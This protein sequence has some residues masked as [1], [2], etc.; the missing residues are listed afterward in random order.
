MRTP[1]VEIEQ[2]RSAVHWPWPP[3]DGA[4]AS[5]FSSGARRSPHAA[6][7]ASPGVPG[8]LGRQRSLA[9]VFGST[10]EGDAANGEASPPRRGSAD[11]SPEAAAAA[12]AAAGSSPGSPYVPHSPRWGRGRA[13]HTLLEY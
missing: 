1:F 11:F 10:A 7:A 5:L 13:C 4:M 9:E 2:R 6:G 3:A 8:G 12:A